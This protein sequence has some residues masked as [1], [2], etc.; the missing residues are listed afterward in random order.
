MLGGWGGR[1]GRELVGE[2]GCGVQACRGLF[3][4]YLSL[5]LHPSLRKAAPAGE[6][7][8]SDSGPLPIIPDEWL[9]LAVHTKAERAAEHLLLLYRS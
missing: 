3:H 7:W 1:G 6:I 2:R 5:S 8:Q 4:M 9:W